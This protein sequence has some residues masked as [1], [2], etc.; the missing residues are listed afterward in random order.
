MNIGDVIMTT[1]IEVRSAIVKPR[2]R[3]TFKSKQNSAM[4]FIACGSVEVGDNEVEQARRVLEYMG[5]AS[6][7]KDIGRVNAAG[8]TIRRNPDSTPSIGTTP[9]VVKCDGCRKRKSVGQ[10]LLGGTVC[11]LCRG[12]K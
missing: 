4:V 1:S 2:I 9:R 8:T 11:K 7:P 10:F 6:L 5:W 12:G 3:A